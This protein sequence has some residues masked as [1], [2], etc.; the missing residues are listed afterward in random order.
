MV[1][2]QK[3]ETRMN[4]MQTHVRVLGILQIVFGAVG[5]LVGV[6][7]VALFGGVAGLLNYNDPD[8]TLT[9]PTVSLA[10]AIILIIAL[11]LPGLI[12]GVGLLFYQPWARTAMIIVSLLQ[13]MNIPLGTALGVYGLWVL[14]KKEGA[15]LFEQQRVSSSTR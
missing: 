3:A 11:A 5:V 4:I 6:G 15:R 10:G 1:G 7:A 2:K 8:A 12:A 9:V 14:S 13:L